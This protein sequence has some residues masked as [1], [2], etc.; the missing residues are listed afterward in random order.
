MAH[1][2]EARENGYAFATRGEPA[3]HGLG[4]VFDKDADITTKQMLELASLQNWNVRLE[5]ALFPEQYNVNGEFFYV[6]RNNPDGNG[7]DV[8]AIVGDRYRVYQNEQLFEFG[9]AI[10]DG[11]A[12]WETAGSIK[13]G[14]QVFGS[15]S[16]PREFILDPQGANDKTLTYL[17]VHS[18]HD[19][20]AAVQAMITPVRVVCQNTLNMALNDASRKRG[21]LKQSFKFRHT[22]TLQQN[23]TQAREAL[24][25]TYSYMDTFEKQ[26]RELFE[27]SVNDKKWNDIITTLYPK[28]EVQEGKK[29]GALTLW[30]N[31]VD[32]LNDLYFK[33]PTNE[34]IKGTGWGAL[35][36]LTER[37]DYFRQSRGNSGE[38]SESNIAA[39]SGFDSQVNAE[40]NRI[41]AVVKELT[42]A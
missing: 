27:T 41:M 39:A 18:S 21:S 28:P 42:L 4:T 13:Q 32:L 7:N 1:D 22:S 35:N 34:T 14:R 31:K 37:V 3:W 6:V 11:G 17:L 24:K 10:L 9:D 2:L 20:S 12:K 5:D 23:A 33:S 30:E 8:L 38:V 29:S 15:L 26:A 36:A 40:K 19:G 16:V 25:L